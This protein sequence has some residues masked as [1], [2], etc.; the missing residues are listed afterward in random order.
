MTEDNF[1]DWKLVAKVRRSLR[2]LREKNDVRGLLGV[3][4]MC[5]RDNF[6]GVES[7]RCVT[8]VISE[9]EHLLI[10]YSDRL[11]S[12]VRRCAQWSPK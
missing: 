9:A 8:F 3:L 6:G 12:E 7:S 2:T 4:E 11:Y 5:V 10:S 1:Y